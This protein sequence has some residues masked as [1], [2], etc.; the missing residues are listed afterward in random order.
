MEQF[1]V[2]MSSKKIGSFQIDPYSSV[3]VSILPEY[4]TQSHNFRYAFLACID[5]KTDGQKT[6]SF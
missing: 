6:V 3:T 4:I 1:L 2:K 5:K